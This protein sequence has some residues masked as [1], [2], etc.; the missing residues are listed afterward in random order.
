MCRKMIFGRT[1]HFIALLCWQ[2]PCVS[3]LCRF[4]PLAVA[5]PDPMSRGLKRVII[6]G[7]TNI[8]GAVAMPDPMSRGLKHRDH[9]L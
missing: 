6:P 3:R 7:I 1:G 5:M 8:I 2:N 9:L 4:A